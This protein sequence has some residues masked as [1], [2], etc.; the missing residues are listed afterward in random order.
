MTYKPTRPCRIVRKETRYRIR[1]HLPNGAVRENQA[2]VYE[3]ATAA[4]ASAN[5]LLSISTARIAP[6][7][8]RWYKSARFEIV[9][10]TFKVG[11]V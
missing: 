6:L 8:R 7:M 11:M 2:E 10:V 5:Y 1:W 9:P 4:E 3:T